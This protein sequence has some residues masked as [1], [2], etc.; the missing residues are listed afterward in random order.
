MKK[1]IATEPHLGFAQ[2]LGLL[3]LYIL[4]SFQEVSN[5]DTLLELRPVPHRATPLQMCCP[6][7]TALGDTGTGDIPIP[8][9]LWTV[10]MSIDRP[11]SCAAVALQRLLPRLE[12]NL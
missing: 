8:V 11:F 9:P 2:V 4:T 6:M 5:L 10:W 7:R 3:V 12:G 1:M